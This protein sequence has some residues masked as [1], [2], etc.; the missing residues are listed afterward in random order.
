MDATRLPRWLVALALLMFGSAGAQ[1]PTG[2]LILHPTIPAS[3]AV[4][5]TQGPQL[6]ELNPARSLTRIHVELT[7]EQQTA[8]VEEGVNV[9]IDCLPFQSIFPAALNGSTEWFFQQRDLNG[10]IRSGKQSKLES[11]L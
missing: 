8:V 4:D 6:L 5:L 11:F 1:M 10:N 9:N 2:A 3:V 7:A